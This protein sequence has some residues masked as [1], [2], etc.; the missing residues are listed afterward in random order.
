MFASVP[1]YVIPC[2]SWHASHVYANAATVVSCVAVAVNAA[3]VFP[4][5]DTWL[6]APGVVAWHALHAPVTVVIPLTALIVPSS[7]FPT[8][9]V[10][11]VLFRCATAA[12]WQLTH[13]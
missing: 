10:S 11:S 1:L 7:R 4:C 6:V 3:F 13:V 2:G 9:V 12:S 5:V 8:Y